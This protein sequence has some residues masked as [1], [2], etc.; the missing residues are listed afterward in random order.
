MASLQ[1]HWPLVVFLSNHPVT[2]ESIQCLSGWQTFPVLHLT[3][4]GQF[5]DKPTRSQSSRGLDDFQT[6]QLTEMFYAKFG[7]NII[8]NVIMTNLL[9]VT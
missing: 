4:T 6:S 8:P 3:L 1:S 5:A 9:S 7:V 2:E